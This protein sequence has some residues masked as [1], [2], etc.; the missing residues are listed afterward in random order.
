MAASSVVFPLLGA[1]TRAIVGSEKRRAVQYQSA[2]SS[3]KYR[4]SEAVEAV[5]TRKGVETSS[6]EV[7]EALVA[8]NFDPTVPAFGG[9]VE[10][11]KEG[12]VESTKEGADAV[13]KVEEGPGDV[14]HAPNADS[15]FEP[16][17]Q[18]SRGGSAFARST[19]SKSSSSPGSDV[20][21]SCDTPIV[22]KKT[23]AAGGKRAKPEDDKGKAST[24]EGDAVE[25]ND[26]EEPQWKKRNRAVAQSRAAAFARGT[27]SVVSSLRAFVL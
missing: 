9:D 2:N 27:G 22:E 13:F 1:L 17:S 19:S 15:D 5:L 8:L 20:L 25:G 3:A 11:T 12:A 4:S 23:K 14:V 6:P 7:R 24:V 18:R 10:S 26:E 21:S 16:P